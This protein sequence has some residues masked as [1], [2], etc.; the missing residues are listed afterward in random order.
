[1]NSSTQHRQQ[2]AEGSG[3]ISMAPWELEQF[4]DDYNSDISEDNDNDGGDDDDDDVKSVEGKWRFAEDDLASIRSEDSSE[5]EE[6]SPDID[7]R[8]PCGAH[9]HDDGHSPGLA[10]PHHPPQQ[11]LN[12]MSA[13][14][15][16]WREDRDYKEC[17][18]RQRKER[19]RRRD[20]W[21]QIKRV[22]PVPKKTADRFTV[23]IKVPHN[24]NYDGIEKKVSEWRQRNLWRDIKREV[25]RIENMRERIT[26]QIEIIRDPKSK[27][28]VTDVKFEMVRRWSA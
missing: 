6:M 17:Q 11:G 14:Q 10:A 16:Y 23:E 8:C 13:W 19:Q 26:L 28:R 21:H 2:W 24:P 7:G 18:Y 12:V 25:P 22:V 15:K 5:D 27:D 4:S 3:D 9:S 20:L 1:M